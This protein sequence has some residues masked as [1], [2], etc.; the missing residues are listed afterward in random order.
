MGFQQRDF[1]LK[2]KFKQLQISALANVRHPS[3]LFI[4]R[5]LQARA[6]SFGRAWDIR[7]GF[8]RIDC[9]YFLAAMQPGPFWSGFRLTGSSLLTLE[10]PPIQ[11]ERLR[12]V[13]FPLRSGLDERTASSFYQ[14]WKT[15]R[16]QGPD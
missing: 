1:K 9:V 14:R 10:A 5:T 6:P 15:F 4:R 3:K 11:P 2:S 8:L 7:A 16:L 12:L 13:E